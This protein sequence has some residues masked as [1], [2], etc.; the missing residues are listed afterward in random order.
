MDSWMFWDATFIQGLAANSLQSRL[1]PVA[2]THLPS[3]HVLPDLDL[4][5]QRHRE[6][7]G[8][9]SMASFTIRLVSSTNGADIFYPALSP[10]QWPTCPIRAEYRG[11]TG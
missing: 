3:A 2:G 9:V 11:R 7:G 4:D 6:A 5:F 8:A 10:S 1:Q